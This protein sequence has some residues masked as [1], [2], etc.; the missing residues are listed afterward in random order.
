MRRAYGGNGLCFRYGGDEFAV[1]LEKDTDSVEALNEAFTAGMR[2]CR[3][4]DPRLPHVSLGYST[5]EP[6]KDSVEGAVVKADEMLYRNK[7]AAKAQ[8]SGS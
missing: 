6:G 8:R 3:Q 7:A 5:F 2:R 4:D 1:L